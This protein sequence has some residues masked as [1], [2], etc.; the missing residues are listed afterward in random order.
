MPLSSIGQTRHEHAMQGPETTF[1]FRRG[2]T[3]LA[4][5]TPPPPPI[6]PQTYGGPVGGNQLVGDTRQ[7]LQPGRP[8][9]LPAALV[10]L[11]V[12]AGPLQHTD[13]QAPRRAVTPCSGGGTSGPTD[14]QLVHACLMFC[15]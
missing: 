2:S 15:W 10:T 7:Q 14:R 5:T 11:P 13:L 12:R 6:P 4:S 9:A 8:H 3:V 1:T